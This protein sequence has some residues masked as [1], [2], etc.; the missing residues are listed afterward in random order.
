MVFRESMGIFT[1]DR[2]KPIVESILNLVISVGI[3]LKFGIIGIFLGTVL[4]MLL[5]CTWVEPWILFK[6]GFK[7]SVKNYFKLYFKYLAIGFV[8]FIATYLINSLIMGNSLISLILHF[9]VTIIVSNAIII[10]LTFKMEEFKY[11]FDIF[12]NILK[13]IKEKFKKHD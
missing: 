11:F 2:W 6:Y 3:T 5:V 7:L 12:K 1:H 10:L 4:S 13:K 9:I 8:A